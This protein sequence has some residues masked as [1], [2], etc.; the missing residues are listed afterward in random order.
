MGFAPQGPL[1][2]KNIFHFVPLTT[3]FISK[4]CRD[5]VESL[6]ITCFFLLEGWSYILEPTLLLRYWRCEAEPVLHGCYCTL[7]IDIH[8]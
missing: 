8:F 2:D 7:A 6:V 4:P 3:I 5:E 1:T